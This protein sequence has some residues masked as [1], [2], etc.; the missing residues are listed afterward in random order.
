MWV[1]SG[2]VPSQEAHTCVRAYMHLQKDCIYTYIYT[3]TYIYIYIYEPH[4]ALFSEPCMRA[5][6]N[7]KQSL[8]P[9]TAPKK[10]KNGASDESIEAV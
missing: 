6:P 8:K 2:W 4:A 5:Y 1:Y 9:R 3:Y 10:K 7:P